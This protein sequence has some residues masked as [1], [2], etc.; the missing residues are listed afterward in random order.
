MSKTE[1]PF[2]IT[3]DPGTSLANQTGTWRSLK[4]EYVDRLPPCNNACPAGENIQKWLYHAEEGDSVQPGI[5]IHVRSSA[6]LDA[7]RRRVPHGNARRVDCDRRTTW[8][9]GSS[10]AVPFAVMPFRSASTSTLS[11]S[12]TSITRR[13]PPENP[14][15]SAT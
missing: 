6:L 14:S 4:P 10:H 15:D 3:L 12:V 8:P 2:A 11:A 13:A 5:A 9:S 7:G 1:L